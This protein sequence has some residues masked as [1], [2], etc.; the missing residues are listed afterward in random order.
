VPGLRVAAPTTA[1]GVLR[2][3]PG[4]DAREVGRQL[5]VGAVLEGTV[6][7]AP[8]RLRLTARLT[9]VDDGLVL[10]QETYDEREGEREGRDVFAVQDDIAR[11]IVAALRPRLAGGGD[12]ATGAT[13]PIAVAGTRDAEA[14]ELYLRGR[15]LWTRRTRLG[16][17]AALLRQAVARDPGYAQA[18]AALALVYGALPDWEK[19][20]RD[21]TDARSVEYAH[22][23]LALDGTLAEPHAALGNAYQLQNRFAEAEREYRLALDAD[24]G[25]A[26]AHQWYGLLLATAGRIDDA[27]RELRRAHQLDPL[28]PNIHYHYASALSSAGQAAEAERQLRALLATEP[29]FWPG[30]VQLAG[31]LAAVW[32]L[33]EA[34]AY[35]DSG[36]RLG[37]ARAEALLW[38][39]AA[40]G[41]IQ[42]RAGRADEARRTLARVRA[43]GA[44]DERGVLSLSEAIVFVSLGQPDSAFAALR[45]DVERGHTSLLLWGL[46]LTPTLDA[47]RDDP[48][49]E[50]LFRRAGFR[51]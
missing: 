43:L 4:A 23:A 24:P 18:Y 41:A 42:A 30:Y 44:R 28:A 48:R 22:R 8:G 50:E 1:A 13:A 20:S 25:N 9:S 5:G 27:V 46:P 49:Y 12:A 31:V 32:R 47:L 35:A 14:H 21:T 16:E 45:R 29:A 11:A 7:R 26:T 15:H 39:L 37:G 34:R 38:P 6:R 17:A 33:E 36:L 40:V 19:V 10:W 2:R 3:R 51:P